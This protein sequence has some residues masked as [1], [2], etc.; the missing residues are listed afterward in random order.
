[1]PCGV[2]G[3]QVRV[4][5]REC[6]RVI[7]DLTEWIARNACARTTATNTEDVRMW[8]DAFV[9]R[10]GPDRTARFG[11]VVSV[12][13]IMVI[14]IPVSSWVFR[15]IQRSLLSPLFLRCV[16][17]GLSLLMIGTGDCICFPGFSGETCD[18][19]S[20]APL[21]QSSPAAGQS[22][23]AIISGGFIDKKCATACVHGVCEDGKCWC[24]NGF[25]GTDCAARVCPKQCNGNGVCNGVTGQCKC[26]GEWTGEDCGW[27]RCPHDCSGNGDCQKDGRCL[28][29]A[30]F[31]G[32][33]CDPRN[34]PNDCSKHGV[35]TMDTTVSPRATCHCMDGW[36]GDDCSELR[37]PKDCSGHGRCRKGFC[38]CGTRLHYPRARVY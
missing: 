13:I 11:D 23:A 9:T 24:D 15:L 32:I 10:D 27:K 16:Y 1:M 14:V 3:V 7:P 37:C 35:C 20:L 36:I 18:K 17:T 8:M 12:V 31:W 21:P 25:T 5:G 26:R 29:N 33:D 4:Y 30:G 34:C 2:V 22:A 28:C 38:Q 6:V 19:T